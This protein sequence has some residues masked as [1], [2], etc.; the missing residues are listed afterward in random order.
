MA[1]WIEPAET[2]LAANLSQ[3]EVDAF[4]RDG[5]L[6]GTDPVAPLLDRTASLVRTWIASGGRCSK[7]GPAGTIPAGL[8]IP[9]MDYAMAKVLNRISVPLTEDRRNALK[10]AEE[11]FDK[12]ANGELRAGRRGRRLDASR[13]VPC[14]RPRHTR[15]AFGLKG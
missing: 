13:L 8:V 12:I 14:C 2:D 11:I 1:N 4:R 7:M 9:A 5:A 3:G 10:R 15:K 6:D